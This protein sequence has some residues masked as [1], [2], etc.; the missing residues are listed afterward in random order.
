VA[1]RLLRNLLNY[2]SR[3]LNKPPTEL[4]IDF[5]QQLKMIRYE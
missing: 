3:D 2:A 4:P 5:I 1:E